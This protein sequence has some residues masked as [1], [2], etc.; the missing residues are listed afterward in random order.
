MRTSPIIALVAALSSAALGQVP[1][2]GLAD[3][4][5]L[6]QRVF[7]RFDEEF[8]LPKA[9]RKG[10]G[11][12]LGSSGDAS[13]TVAVSPDTASSRNIVFQD[14]AAVETAGA[15][16]AAKPFC[17]LSAP[18][19]FKSFRRGEVIAFLGRTWK[20]S[21]S[22]LNQFAGLR[23]MEYQEAPGKTGVN[24]HDLGIDL[25]RAEISINCWTAG[26]E[27]TV[28][29][30]RTALG[31]DIE[32]YPY[33]NL[34]RLGLQM[35]MAIFTVGQAK[36]YKPYGPIPLKDSENELEPLDIKDIKA[37]V[38]PAGTVILPPRELQ[39][40]PVVVP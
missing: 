24:G 11:P 8:E 27:G 4:K 3:E 14:G 28:G 2:R 35:P 22:S 26:A 36:I 31:K 6:P 20:I 15:W 38:V 21:G 7:I 16:D 29:A 32:V 37:G 9:L 5:P 1:P 19:S 40:E 13:L 17:A 34:F 23:A 12:A 33:S 18:G 39:S 30:L 10:S 25:A